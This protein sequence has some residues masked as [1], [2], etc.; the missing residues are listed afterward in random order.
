VDEIPDFSG[1]RILV[2]DDV[3]INRMII[4]SFLKGTNLSIDEAEN[5]AIAVDMITSAPPGHYD[6]VFMDMQMPVM[7]G[8]SATRAIRSSDHPD[9]K[10][11]PIIAMTANVFKDDVQA[12]LAAGMNGHIGKPVDFPHVLATI[13]KVI[14]RKNL[15]ES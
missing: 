15:E 9:A 12:V 10:T 7:D 6:L 1:C 8:C 13:R 11:L 4:V 14:Q 5:G 3:V 2:A